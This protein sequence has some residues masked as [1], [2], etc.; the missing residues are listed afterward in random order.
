MVELAAEGVDKDKARDWLRLRAAKRLPLTP[1]AWQTTKDEAAKVGMTPAAAVADSVARDRAGF[2]ASWVQRDR[3]EEAGA[4]AGRGPK[5]PPP[6]A[7]FET[8]NYR[9]GI[10]G[11]GAL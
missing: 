2:R 6:A 8:R 1:S 9:D 4:P 3:R 7:A 11:N 5:G 10:G